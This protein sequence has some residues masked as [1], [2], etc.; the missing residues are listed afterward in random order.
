[1]KKETVTTWFLEM[2]SQDEWLHKP[3]THPDFVIRE[4]Q[5]KQFQFNRFL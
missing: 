3:V 1:M 2:T 4:C 5:V